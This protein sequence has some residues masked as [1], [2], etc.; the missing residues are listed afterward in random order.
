M[1]VEYAPNGLIGLLTP[2]ANT[3]A[4]IEFSLLM[5]A[6]IAPLV[7][8]M[9]SARSS[10]DARLVEYFEQLDSTIAQFANAPL[11]ALAAACTGSSY[12]LGRNREDSLFAALSDRLGIPVTS[13]ALSVVEACRAMGAKRIALVSPYPDSLTEASA[14][15][16]K[17]RSLEISAIA[18]VGG[19]S[20]AFHPI[21]SIAGSAAARSLGEL[22]NS[23]AQ[24]IVLLGTGMPSLGVV[25]EQPFVDGVPVFS[26]MLALAWNAIRLSTGSRSDGSALLEFLSAKDWRHRYQER[27][28]AKDAAAGG[29]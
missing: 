19:D 3:T 2:Q 9:T 29:R 21:Y 1:T 26:C 11:S 28:R 15:Y 25:L 10:L 7:A 5:P 20:S 6:G 27:T 4:E 23:G 12:L 14:A 16:W 24:A 18:R 22:R 8:R 17:S 13:A